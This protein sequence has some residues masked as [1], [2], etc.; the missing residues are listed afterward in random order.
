MVSV[1][2]L[3]SIIFMSFVCHVETVSMNG[4]LDGVNLQTVLPCIII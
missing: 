3:P 1:P 4:E 2:S